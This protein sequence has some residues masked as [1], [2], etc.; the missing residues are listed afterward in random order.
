MPM[1]CEDKSTPG[2][3]SH[4]PYKKFREIVLH[5]SMSFRYNGIGR[6]Y[7]NPGPGS[8]KFQQINKEGK[9]GSSTLRN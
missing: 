7:N 9:Y 3:S 4:N 1:A 8:Y 5:F 6:N 2:P